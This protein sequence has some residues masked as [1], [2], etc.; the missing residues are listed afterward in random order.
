[1]PKTLVSNSNLS[2]L[3]VVT[4][5]DF[6]NNDPAR[7]NRIIRLL[8]TQ[9]NGVQTGAASDVTNI[10]NVTSTAGKSSSGGSSPS[11]PS[12]P[13]S[14]VVTIEDTHANR[15]S[16]HLPSSSASGT[17]YYETDRIV[18]YLN[19]T[20]P[21]TTQVWQYVTGIME[22]VIANQPTDL[23]T[24]DAGFLFYAT[25]RKILYQWS[26]SAWAEFL[27]SQ[28]IIEDTYANW[29]LANYNP[30]NY[31]P[32]TL[33][34]ITDRNL[35]YSVQVVTAVN[36]WVYVSGVYIAAA[37]S[38]PTTG[39]NSVALG[40]NDTN[41]MFLAT[42]SVVFEYW[43]GAA[44]VIVKPTG[45]SAATYGDGTHV[46]VIVVDANGRITGIS[47]TLITG[48]SP[49]GSTLASGNIIVGNALNVAASVAMSQDTT[50][51]NTGKVTVAGSQGDFA[52]KGNIEAITAG[53]GFQVKGGSNARIGSGTLV[54]GTLAVANT[55]VTANT[56]I[57]L[58]DQGGGVIANIGSLYV[59]SQT[60]TTGFTVTS[61]N[62][63]DTSSFKYLLIEVL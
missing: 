3:P 63:I 35:L 9:L 2:G 60:A 21:A 43:S 39:F 12:T 23:G 36:A 4:V 46:A 13:T 54:G 28:P 61:T 33:F 57:F 1:M 47:N 17:Y 41:L 18:T 5:E 29:T 6:K 59:A 25:D 44:W 10:T 56:A 20:T 42:D 22:S 31:N 50:I 55:S 38:R 62:P 37:A 27:T 11:T 7:L 51:D 16:S 26:G 34:I 19:F 49:L 40:V 8:A 32:G 14:S 45:A 58:T 24:Y 53:K 30:V 52:G 48:T 15:L